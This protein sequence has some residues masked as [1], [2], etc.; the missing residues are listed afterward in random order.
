MLEAAIDREAVGTNGAVEPGS[1][2]A[3][4]PEDGSPEAEPFAADLE[5]QVE[6]DRI[7]RRG[8]A[9]VLRPSRRGQSQQYKGSAQAIN[10]TLNIVFIVPP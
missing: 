4:E 8:L 10:A 3:L 6:V 7:A 2:H 9:I 1:V 5:V